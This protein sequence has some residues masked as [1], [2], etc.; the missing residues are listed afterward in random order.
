MSFNA[1]A[2]EMLSEKYCPAQKVSVGPLAKAT[3]LR[4][5]DW[6]ISASYSGPVSGD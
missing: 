2:I 6:V 1:T 3:H 4:S 5:L